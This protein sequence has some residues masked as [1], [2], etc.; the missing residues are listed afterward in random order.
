MDKVKNIL[1]LPLSNIFQHSKRKFKF[2][3]QFGALIFL[4]GWK[5][6][7]DYQATCSS[8]EMYATSLAASTHFIPA[9]ARGVI[10]V[11]A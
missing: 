7:E 4:N 5:T 3:G 11:P 9:G 8:T 1:E 2:R 10:V 6:T